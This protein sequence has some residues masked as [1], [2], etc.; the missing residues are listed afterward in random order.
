MSDEDFDRM[1]AAWF[2]NIARVLLPG[3]G[4]YIR[5][6]YANLGNYPSVLKSCGLYFSRGY[7]VGQAEPEKV[8]TRFYVPKSKEAELTDERARRLR[9]VANGWR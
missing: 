4:F 2:G 8:R 1:L 6:G 7:R 5:G 9:S 3:R